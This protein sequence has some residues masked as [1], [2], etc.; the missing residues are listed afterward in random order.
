MNG[1]FPLKLFITK[2][3]KFMKK[4][5]FC[6]VATLVVSAAITMGYQAYCNSDMSEFMITNVEALSDIELLPCPNGCLPDGNGCFCYEW[7]PYLREGIK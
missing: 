6:A 7:S 4:Y 2:N 1:V 3:I 5:I